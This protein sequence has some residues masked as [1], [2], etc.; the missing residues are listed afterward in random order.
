MSCMELSR[1][2][3]ILLSPRLH[4]RCSAMR[5]NGATGRQWPDAISSVIP[6]RVL[7]PPEYLYY[8]LHI[9]RGTKHEPG[10]AKE[11]ENGWI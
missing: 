4:E 10:L 1:E 11:A 3:E 7:E 9:R 2:V 5:M 6:R 8:W